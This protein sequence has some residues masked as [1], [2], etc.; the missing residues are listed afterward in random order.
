MLCYAM[1]CHSND[2]FLFDLFLRPVHR[3]VLICTTS[4]LRLT[5]EHQHLPPWLLEYLPWPWNKSTQYYI[6]C[7]FLL[8][9]VNMFDLLTLS[10]FPPSV[11]IL[12]GENCS[13]L[14]SG[15]QSMILCPI[16]R[17]GRGT[18]QGWWSIAGLVL[19]FS[20]LKPWWTSLTQSHGSMCLKRS[21]V[22]SEMIL[23]S[24]GM[25]RSNWYTYCLIFVEN[26]TN[27]C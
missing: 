25:W 14:W 26:V 9:C 7:Y 1:R 23:S 17:A 2:W 11:Q 10:F 13:T 3:L 6:A 18:E 22:S 19:A 4:A 15:P 21:S 8:A 5:Q 24:Q 16:T 27:I 12:P 20:M